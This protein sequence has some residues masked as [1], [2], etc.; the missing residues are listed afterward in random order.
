MGFKGSK[1]GLS[2]F[3]LTMLNLRPHPNR[4]YTVMVGLELQNYTP[5]RIEKFDQAP[6]REPCSLANC[7]CRERDF[8]D[9]RSLGAILEGMKQ[10]GCDVGLASSCYE[11]MVQHHR[12]AGA[13]KK[14]TVGV[15]VAATFYLEGMSSCSLQTRPRLHHFV[16]GCFGSR[17]GKTT[18]LGF[19]SH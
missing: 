4:F 5:A 12:F 1:Q 17:P 8:R 10:V 11:L 16:S 7:R 3:K 15:Q 13:P 2:V 9:F 18:L 6:T 14:I 19:L